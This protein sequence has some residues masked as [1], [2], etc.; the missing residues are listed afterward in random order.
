M[1]NI[2][3]ITFLSSLSFAGE[4]HSHSPGGELEHAWPL[5]IAFVVLVILAAGFNYFS[6]KK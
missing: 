4:E 2:L 6:K 3:L 1:R 5:F